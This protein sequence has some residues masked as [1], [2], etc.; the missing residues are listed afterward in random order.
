MKSKQLANV[1]IKLLGLSVIVHN[2]STLIGGMLTMIQAG[3]AS[4]AGEGSF[5]IITSV[6][7]T[8]VGV[9]LIVKSRAVAELL[10]G[11]EDE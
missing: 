5:F 9:F 2:L 1:L 11:A 3:R 10:L 4:V 8:F 7:T 6:L